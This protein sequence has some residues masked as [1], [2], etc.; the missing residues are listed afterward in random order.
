MRIR[1][2]LRAWYRHARRIGLRSQAYAPGRLASGRVHNCTATQ[3]LSTRTTDC[4][5]VLE[6]THASLIRQKEVHGDLLC[7]ERAK[8]RSGAAAAEETSALASRT[9]RHS[10]QADGMTEN[11]HGV[12]LRKHTVGAFSG[13][14]PIVL[15][16]KWRRIACCAS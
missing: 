11:A 13:D 8:H 16:Q 14:S 3:L 10:G 5:V 6:L 15:W 2:T 4:T 9:A 7:A 1:C 12:A